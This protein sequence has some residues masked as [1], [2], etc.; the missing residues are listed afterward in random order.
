MNM[1]YNK[2][3]IL[4]HIWP[5]YF[6][7]RNYEIEGHEG[8]ELWGMAT[9]GQHDWTYRNFKYTIKNWLGCK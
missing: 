9:V 7:Y 1:T 6:A 8:D 3:G 5:K 2:R 4:A